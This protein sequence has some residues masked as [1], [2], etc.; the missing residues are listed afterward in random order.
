LAVAAA[1]IVNAFSF[2]A[3]FVDDGPSVAAMDGLVSG[4]GELMGSPRRSTGALSWVGPLDP[5]QPASIN[6]AANAEDIPN[7]RFARIRLCLFII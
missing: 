1:A 2:F 6:A 3:A 5:E 7:R 4:L